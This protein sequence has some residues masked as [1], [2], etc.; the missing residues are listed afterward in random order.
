MGRTAPPV[1]ATVGYNEAA[2]RSRLTIFE[3]QHIVPD[4][5]PRR[6][7]RSICR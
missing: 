4:R 7:C 6:G 2:H 5:S 3:A 1:Q